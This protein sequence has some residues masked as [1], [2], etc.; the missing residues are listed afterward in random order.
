[1]PI[2]LN[3]DITAPPATWCD[4]P[5][6]MAYISALLD[7]GNTALLAC[8]T[9]FPVS[10]PNGDTAIAGT[11]A[12]FAQ[13]NR[14]LK[15]KVELYRGFSTSPAGV[16]TPNAANLAAAVTAINAS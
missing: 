7:S 14:G 6:V 4:K 10:L 8:G 11:P 9:A 12:K 2:A 13:F 5:S 3:V 1:M 16:V 15:A